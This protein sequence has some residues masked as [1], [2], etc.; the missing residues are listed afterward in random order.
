MTAPKDLKIVISGQ[1]ENATRL[2]IRAGKF[3]LIIDEPQSVGG[4]DAGPSPVQVLLM[5]LAGCINVTGHHIAKE[6]GL[7]LNGMQLTIEGIMNPAAFYGTSFEERAGFKQ[8]NVSVDADFSGASYQEIEEWLK[9][10]E[11]RCPVT[12]N[13]MVNTNVSVKIKEKK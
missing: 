1:S 6:K 10:T 12:D 7:R 8:I 4:T 5:A 2:N 3:N 9:E 11:R 13:I